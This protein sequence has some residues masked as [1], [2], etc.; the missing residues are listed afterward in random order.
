MPKSRSLVVDPN[1][2]LGDVF[3]RRLLGCRRLADVDRREAVVGDRM[4]PFEVMFHRVLVRVINDAALVPK[5]VHEIFP[6]L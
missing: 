6:N 4:C 1:E 2:D 3:F 5:R